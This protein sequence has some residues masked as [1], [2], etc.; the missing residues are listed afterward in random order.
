MEKKN[1]EGVTGV[2]A[3]YSIEEAHELIDLIDGMEELVLGM[4]HILAGMK[5]LAH[6]YRVRDPSHR[7]KLSSIAPGPHRLEKDR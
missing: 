1:A 5:V 3:D 2:R 6:G 4:Q 7:G